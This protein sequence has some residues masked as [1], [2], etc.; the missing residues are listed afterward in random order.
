MKKLI[1]LDY[2]ATTPIDPRVAEAILPYI[3]QHFGNPSSSH[4]YGI[5]TKKAV[6][7]ARK[8]IAEML[9]CQ[10]DEIIFTSG[11][12]ES[13]NYA[14]KGAARAYR[15]KGNHI[16]TSSIEHPAVV[17][18]CRYL[19]E[20]GHKVTYL[21]VDKYGLVDPKQLEE[22]ITPETVLITVMHANNEVGTI[23]PIREI[24]E[25][26]HRHGILIH[27]DCAQS[28]GKIP[29][30]VDD[31]GVDLLSIAGHKLYAPKG[32]GA[33]YIRSGVKLEKLIHGAD[34]ERNLRAGTENVIEIVGLGEAC[35]LISKNLSQY[36]KHM[37]KMRDR[38]EEGLKKRFSNIRVN[39]H[40]EKRLPNTSSVSFKGLEA[41][42]ILSEL[43][44]VAASAGAACHSDRVDVSSVLQA[45]DVPIEFAMGTL[46][47]SVGRTT[48][49]GEIDQ[50]IEDLARIVEKLQ[51][52]EAPVAIPV[53]TQK[54]R[55]TQFTHGL[56]CA[57]KLRPQLLEEV[58]KKMPLP[59]DKNILVGTNTADDAAI[60]RIDDNTAIVQTVDF[61]TPVVD[62]PFQFGVIAAVNSLSDIYAMG[63]KP[64]FA[65]NIVGFPSNRLSIRVL[66][67]ILKGSQSIAAKTGISIIG[68]HTVDDTE[69]KFGLAVTGLIH[70]DKIL[71]NAGAQ[72]GDELI[73][74]KPIGTGILST[75]MKQDLLEDDQ[76]KLLFEMM[77]S[78]NREA[79]EAMQEAGAHACTDITG[80]GLLGHLLE[81]MNGSQTSAIVD[82][83]K[84]PFLS[85]VLELAASGII[86]GGTKD[87][88]D[89]TAPFVQ[90]DEKISTSKRLVLN[91]AQTSGGLL[92]SVPQDN[93][94]TLLTLLKEKG[95]EEA[96]GIGKV[97]SEEKARIIVR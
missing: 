88:H 68:G 38:L 30:H 81:M 52:K 55:L 12:S 1:Y 40:P 14:I 94:A 46:R 21:P 76:A 13:I 33:L 75:A 63:G 35:E 72:P 51:P 57:C 32:I 79:A 61:F 44:T 60:Y 49:A 84:V 50:A 28:I 3:H 6:E 95:V 73:L 23:E 82:E 47:L 66:E 16:I 93:A 92:I 85:G 71:T 15:H 77:A 86:P 56:G 41:N 17:E 8:Q 25:M 65:L 39:G 7:K 36:S 31:L 89:F 24:S 2:N 62:D 19:E 4:A 9:R 27:T 42:T 29:V 26:G 59:E 45:M 69:P 64:L 80:F 48:S 67:E 74:T 58:L 53:D 20:Q 96:K 43:K 11:G 83:S 18:V 54:I 97:I 70:P 5:T 91:D 10:I 90:Y 34:H 87:N 22:S 37:M 78:L